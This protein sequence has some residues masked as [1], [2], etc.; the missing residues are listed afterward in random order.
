M[1]KNVLY[2]LEAITKALKAA[3]V[4]SQNGIVGLRN[5]SKLG[6][7]TMSASAPNILTELRQLEGEMQRFLR[8]YR[9]QLNKAAVSTSTTAAKETE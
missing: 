2:E 5:I 4:R 6:E 8:N 7:A 9:D 1:D 3:I